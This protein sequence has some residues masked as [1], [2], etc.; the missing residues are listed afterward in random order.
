MKRCYY[1]IIIFVLLSC[2]SDQTKPTNPK[3]KP[4]DSSVTAILPLGQIENRQILLLSRELTS[5]YGMKILVL[6]KKQ[7]PESCLLKNTERYDAS[8]MLQWLKKQK[9]T[10]CDRILGITTYDVYTQKGKYPHWGIFGLGYNPGEACIVSDHRLKQFANRRDTFL[11]L[12]TLHEI[13]HN[14]GL[15][16]CDKHA[17]CLMND[18]KGTAKTLFAEKKWLCSN[19]R[20]LLQKS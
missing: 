9:P 2:G 10:H 3:V 14:L 15:P 7:M 16:H 17:S 20:K 12:V 11:T 6:P 4:N 18:A 1:L 13:G 8:A 5:F 19:C